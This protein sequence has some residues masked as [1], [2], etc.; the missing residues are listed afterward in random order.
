MYSQAWT[1]LRLA[2]HTQTKSPAH[3]DRR[4]LEEFGPTPTP[5]RVRGAGSNARLSVFRH[6]QLQE[7]ASG[8]EV[9]T[10][11]HPTQAKQATVGSKAPG[12]S[13]HSPET[14]GSCGPYSLKT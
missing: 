4:G 8:L 3:R 13:L 12:I 14:S 9:P 1:L 6:P 10:R 2:L 5:S 11:L 7:E